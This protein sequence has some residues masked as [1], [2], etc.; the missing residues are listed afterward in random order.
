MFIEKKS[1]EYIFKSITDRG[2]NG[3]Q[4][5]AGRPFL[6]PDFSPEIV[7][8]KT[9]RDK[10]EIEVINELKLK[11]KNGTF[12][13][14][15]PSSRSEENPIDVFGLMYSLDSEG[16]DTECLTSDGE[17]GYWVGEEYS[18][19]LIHLSQNG[20]MTRRFMPNAEIPRIYSERKTN[21]GFEAI[22]K[23]DNKLL[24][25]LQSPLSIDKKFSRIVEVDLDSNKT[26][27][28]Y[29]YA[30]D[31][32]ADRIGDAVPLPDKTLL[33]LEQNGKANNESYKKIY[34]IKL[35]GSDQLVT[36]KLFLDLD[37]TSFKNNEKIEGIAII[38]KNHIAVVNDNDFAITA[39]T[40][41]KTGL[42]P[43]KGGPSQL[44]IIELDQS[45]F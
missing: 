20:T 16:V 28:E 6:L 43:L 33:V 2:P 17:D 44:M 34:R 42:T 30:I 22:A 14:G 7:T 32:K 12:A 31:E 36:K 39:E 18:P 15:L 25:F 37:S 29:F 41:F 26:S 19:S 21:R 9:N 27:A 5:K 3:W 23:I 35:N 10:K 45:L 38:D 1:G 4:V 40:D 11:R 13:S 24:G 8:L